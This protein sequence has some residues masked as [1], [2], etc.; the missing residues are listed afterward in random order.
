V[1]R[2]AVE[3]AVHAGAATPA[4]ARVEDE[5]T[6]DDLLGRL[7]HL[8]ASVTRIEPGR[9]HRTSDLTLDLGLDS[10]G[11]LELAAALED[12]FGVVVDDGELADLARV[13]ELHGLIDDA[14]HPV[15]EIPPPTWP[16][17]PWARWLRD[18]LQRVLLFPV[19]RLVARP[20]VVEGRDAAD[21]ITGPVLIVAN[22]CSH[23]DTPSILRALPWRIRRRTAVAAA[24]DYF[25]R[26][27]PIGSLAT[28]ILGTFPF[29]RE[30]AVRSS[31]ER[32][33]EFADDGWS[34]LIYPE[35]TRSPSG[36]TAPF[37]S[38]IGLLATQLSVPIVPIGVIGTHRAW[39]K[40]QRLPRPGPVTVRIGA[41]VTVRPD[42]DPAE[43]V[44]RLE[45]AVAALT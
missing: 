4:P 26:S 9:I 34:V 3:E 37:R 21:G 35:G 44:E 20:F 25:Y 41:P 45:R 18:G 38:G 19:H 8:L 30:G 23:L 22:H 29:V 28:L 15:P 12:E 40:G 14:A 31:L 27:R 43:P 10:L 16:Q 13:D 11:L 7:R 32:C 33:G 6:E 36:A 2:F 5:S 17:A 39:P 24:A 1:R 42:A